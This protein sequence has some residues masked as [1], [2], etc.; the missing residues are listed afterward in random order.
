M[1]AVTKRPYWGLLP[2]GLLVWIVAGQVSSH[3]SV[4]R[5][6]SDVLEGSTTVRF[7]IIALGV[8]VLCFVSGIVA[9]RLRGGQ[10]VDDRD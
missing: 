7:L 5:H 10:I 6:Y 2:V 9:V 4:G 8:F 3:P 1:T